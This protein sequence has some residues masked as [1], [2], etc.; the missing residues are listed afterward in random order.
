MT[1]CFTLNA[2]E[3][4]EVRCKRNEYKKTAHDGGYRD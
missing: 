1:D 4:I 2:V 3:T